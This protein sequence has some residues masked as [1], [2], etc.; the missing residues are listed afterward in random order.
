MIILLS[1]VSMLQQQY[2]A[3]YLRLYLRVYI[4]LIVFT[5]LYAILGEKNNQIAF[6]HSDRLLVRDEV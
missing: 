3:P 2:G 1:T 5:T 6:L 4:E